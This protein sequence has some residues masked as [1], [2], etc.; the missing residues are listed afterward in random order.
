[1][2]FEGM[3]RKFESCRAHHDSKGFTPVATCCNWAPPGWISAGHLK[4]MDPFVTD[5]SL[6]SLQ[7]YASQTNLT[8]IDPAVRKWLVQEY[9][10]PLGQSNGSSVPRAKKHAV[11]V[12]TCRCGRKIAGNVHFRHIKT[13]R[14][15]QPY[16]CAFQIKAGSQ[17]Y[18][19]DPDMSAK[20]V[21]ARAKKLRL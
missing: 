7:K 13:C 20:R 16:R 10:L 2:P 5:R 14:V 19:P 3:S 9:G 4:V 15:A 1:M 17:G 21:D 18:P 12:R 11:T 8:L 6:R